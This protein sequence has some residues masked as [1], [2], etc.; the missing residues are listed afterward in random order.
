MAGETTGVQAEVL[1]EVTV[2]HERDVPGALEGGADRLHLVRTGPEGSQS[3]SPEL[4]SAVCR[5]SDV[6]VFVLLRLGDSWTTTGG[7][8][9]RLVGLA[10]D[11]L[12]SGAAGVSFGFLDADL[13]VDSAVCTH[14]A[15]RLDGVPWTFHRAFDAALE[16][17]RAWRRALELPGLVAVRTAGSP[18]GL[19]VGFDDLLATLKS[20]PR[21][22]AL[23]MP[24]GGL[25]AE[26]VPWLLRA[27]VRQVHLGVQVRP[28]ATYRSYVDAGHV[29]SWRLLLDDAGARLR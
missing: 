3:P 8:L 15:E 21:I 6:P 18:R 20:D 7:E 29:R 5:H 9:A 2:L 19:E 14:L 11:Y 23:A 28:G 16:P 4:V 1:L 13:G 22:A 24:G 25:V 27:G 12:G 26:H 17:D 10:H